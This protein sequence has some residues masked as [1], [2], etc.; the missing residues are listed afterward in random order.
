M[1]II[2]FMSYVTLITGFMMKYN[3]GLYIGR[4]QP[5][6]K[7]HKSIVDK[8]LRECDKVII[9][10]GSAQET[11]T[12]NNPFRYEYRK[13][14]IQTV[15]PAIWNRIIIIGIED[16]INP[17]DDSSWGEYVINNIKKATDIIPDAIYQGIE[18][19]HSNWF[20]TLNIPIIEVDRGILDVTGTKVRNAL[21]QNHVLRF[22]AYM[23]NALHQEYEDMKKVVEY[24]EIN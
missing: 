16:R 1:F 8:M 10:I 2:K 12:K 7:G 13:W 22:K 3:Y 23:P 15:Y 6:H 5:F 21:L 4:F 24:V 14:M 9:A 19:K 18:D 11:E 20:S 17:S